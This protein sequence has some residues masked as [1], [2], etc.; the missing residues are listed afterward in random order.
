MELTKKVYIN[1]CENCKYVWWYLG[2][3][4]CCLLENRRSC[5][6]DIPEDEE[7][8]PWCPLENADEKGM[9]FQKKLEK[10]ANYIYE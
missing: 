7:I 10:K 2:R 4:P 1:S 5:W 6:N 8:P 9:E 3:S